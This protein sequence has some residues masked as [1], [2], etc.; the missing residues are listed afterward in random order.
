MSPWGPIF[1][2]PP[3][4][5]ADRPEALIPAVRS[6]IAGYEPK[7]DGFL[8]ECA[9]IG[10]VLNSPWDIVSARRLDER[11]L[12]ILAKHLPRDYPIPKIEGI[13]LALG[14]K[15]ARPH[16]L[17][18]VRDILKREARSPN[19]RLPTAAANTLLDMATKAD[20]AYFED[21]LTD[22]AYDD[23]RVFFV[24]PYARFAKERAIPLL[25]RLLQQGLFLEEVVNELGKLRDVGSRPEI[26]A[27]TADQRAHVRR[28]A[29]K[30][31]ER[32]DATRP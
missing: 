18:L 27:L 11:L 4:A 6:S 31:L 30:A 24:R 12:P 29:R 19:P 3:E 10:W 1:A 22:E 13:I 21:V 23:Y 32:L 25:R 17:N 7:L 14:H 16:A 15:E 5:R 9:A 26:A 8:A 28:A 2:V 20:V